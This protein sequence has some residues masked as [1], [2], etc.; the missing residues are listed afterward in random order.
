MDVGQEEGQLQVGGCSL[1]T[2]GHT[3]RGERL[4]VQDVELR[5]EGCT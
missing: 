3:V 2:V 4:G 1:E 5:R